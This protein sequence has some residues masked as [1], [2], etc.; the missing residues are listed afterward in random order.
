MVIT[1][2]RESVVVVDIAA[3]LGDFEHSFDDWCGDWWFL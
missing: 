1:D 3:K 2:W